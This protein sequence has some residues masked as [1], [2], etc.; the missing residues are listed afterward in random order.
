MRVE[1]LGSSDA[2]GVLESVSLGDRD[3]HRDK[4]V[5][6]ML[7]PAE[8]WSCEGGSRGEGCCSEGRVAESSCFATIVRCRG[9]SWST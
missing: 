4:S 5:D 2:V 3:V 7:S 9:R 8:G 1:R 6:S